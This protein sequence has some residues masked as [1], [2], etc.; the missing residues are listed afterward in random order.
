M[1]KRLAMLLVF[2]L[3]DA[4]AAAAGSGGSAY[5]IFGV[6]DLR[7]PAGVRAA[8]MGGAGVGLPTPLSINPLS[9]AS[10]SRISRVRLDAG[11]LYEG[12][13]SSDGQRSLFRAAAT[14]DGALL[15]IPVS[16]DEGIVIAAGFLPYSSVNYHTF[17]RGV[18]DGTDYLLNHRGD[19]GLTRGLAGFSWRPLPWLSAGA[20]F[21][22][23]F[24]SRDNSLTMTIPDPAGGAPATGT[25]TGSEDARG[26]GAGLSVLIENLGPA[27]TA[28]HTF[29][30][31]FVVESRAA[32]TTTAR[33]RYAFPTST[34]S[35][36]E[37]SGSTSLPLTLGA[38]VGYQLSDRTTL[39]AD[40]LA[41]LWEQ[42]AVN[43][44]RPSDI[45]NATRFALGIERSPSRDPQA[46]WLER[47]TY[48]AGARFTATAVAPGGNP[49]NEWA[50]TAGAGIPAG[51]GS[52]FSVTAELARRA[53]TQQQLISDTIVRVVLSL[54]IGEEWFVRPPEE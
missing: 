10:W 36:A 41:Q 32:L 24:G 25:I 26:A 35:S 30:L 17:S 16:T 50:L 5:S 23:Y 29:S 8:G 1:T 51:G 22:Y 19:G 2:L 15:A 28:F 31:G 46:P 53:A 37:V 49:V 9:A 52:V 13:R 43:G 42:T 11:L 44:R 45:R 40:V 4:L 18:Q 39:A 20:T 21:D 47:L 3:A 33:T 14:F 48:R 54:S 6:G 34:D 38:G 27:G 7:Y 12:F